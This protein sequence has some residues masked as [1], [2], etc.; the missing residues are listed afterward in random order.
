[1]ALLQKLPHDQAADMSP[2]HP[3]TSYCL[4]ECDGSCAYESFLAS[5]R[6]EWSGVGLTECSLPPSLYPFQAS[7]TSWALRKG[8]AAIF[9]D[10]GLGKT[11]M[12]LAWAVNIPGPVLILAP[13]CVGE[14][15]IAEGHRIG[16]PV[17]PH[18]AGGQIEIANYERLHQVDTGQYDGIVLDESSIL[19]AYDG[20]TRTRL[21]RAFAETPYRLCCTATPAPNDIAELANHCEFLGIM[22]R[23][24]MLAT[25]FV[26]DE[27][28]WRLKGH[29]HE[30]FYR[31]LVSW[32]IFMRLPSDLGF[33]D[34]GY[35]LPG[36]EI[37]EHV[38]TMDAPITGEY[39]FP[40]MGLGGIGGRTK[41]RR[42]SLKPRV[43]RVVELVKASPG[44]WIVW[45][46]LNDESSTASRLLPDS[47]EVTGSDSYDRKVEVA[48]WFSGKLC[49]CEHEK[50][51][52]NTCGTGLNETEIGFESMCGREPHSAM[53]D[54]DNAT[55][56]MRGI[57]TPSRPRLRRGR[58]NIQR[59][60][61]GSGLPLTG[62]PQNNTGLSF[63]NKVVDAPSVER[64]RRRIVSEWITATNA[65]ISEDS[66]VSPAI[67]GSA[68]SAIRPAASNVPPCTCGHVSGRRILITKPAIFGHGLNFQHCH[69]MAFLGLGDSYETYYQSIRR[70]YR[71]G[72]TEPVQV[73]I[74]VSE[75]ETG[76]VRNVQ[77]K[78]VE[79]RRMAEGLLD[80]VRVMEREEVGVTERKTETLVNET[81]RGAAWTLHYGDSVAVLPTVPEASVDFS[82]YS[83]P[84]IAL[85]TYTNS[86]R[87][88]GNCATR[89]EVLAHYAYVVREVLRV[90]KPG[91][92]SA[93]H[94]AQTTT[95]K[96]THGIIGLTDLRGSVIALHVREGW[97]YHG[98]VCI[99]KDPQAQAIRKKSKALLFVQLR[100]DSSWLRP[101]LR[102]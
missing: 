2:R 68:N 69:Q 72:Q 54:A 52:S 80:A 30:A 40:S 71:F 77:Q 93:V 99:D 49:L 32:G 7:L 100:K 18:G 13:L 66:S 42:L 102:S 20:K 55:K 82:V 3:C 6:R 41:A 15:T 17:R 8:R 61:S 27:D 85:Y 57:G 46:G 35:R 62:L 24:E 94:I 23:A 37:R 83:P 63:A 87:D 31:W 26:H 51:S 12:Q 81:S 45:C 34:D 4:E 43:D 14:Q 84:F 50:R 58:A 73:H 11:A 88:I 10:T 33:E 39:L 29:A 70:C 59:P 5:K 98:E 67:L 44:P 74:V 86:E 90:T 79:A 28:G 65:A 92:L 47:Q 36:L 95:T 56:K 48:A 1:M 101:A 91:R 64:N 78:E 96:A 75:A 19:K 9:A 16:V 38:V 25:W 76:I 22:T 97:I 53:P 21:I 89:E 60:G